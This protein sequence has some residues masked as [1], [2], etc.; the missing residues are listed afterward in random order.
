[1]ILRT[2]LALACTLHAAAAPV[3]ITPPDLRGA[4]QPQ[5]A[6]GARGEIN[7]VFGRDGTICHS[8]STDEARTFPNF[9]TT[10]P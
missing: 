10:S 4:Q 6:V 8:V 5:V 2:L 7:V 9:K 1:M 3:E